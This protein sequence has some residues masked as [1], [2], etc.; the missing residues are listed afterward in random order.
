MMK[1]TIALIFGLIACSSQASAQ[2]GPNWSVK[3]GYNQF[4]PQV[5]SGEITGVPEGKVDV[6][7]GGGVFGSVAYVLSERV[8]TELAFGIP[9]KL[10]IIGRGSIGMAGKIADTKVWAPV[11]MLQYHLGMPDSTLRPY[12]GL[13]ATYMRYRQVTTT[14]V[15]SMLTN[16]GGH[17]SATIDN[18]WGAVAQVGITCPFHTNWFVDAAIVPIR[19]KTTARLSSGQRVKVSVDPVLVNLAIGLRF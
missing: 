8:S 12:L 17:T 16:P 5:R 7:D 15:L 11:L 9:P 18:A 3:A 10:D 19:V 1:T 6:S 14:P 4:Y 13:G 2:S